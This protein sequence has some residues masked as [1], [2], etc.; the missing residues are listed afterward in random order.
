MTQTDYTFSVNNPNEHRKQGSA[1]LIASIP[2]YQWSNDSSSVSFG[3][4]WNYLQSEQ[5]IRRLS[6]TIQDYATNPNLRPQEYLSDNHLGLKSAPFTGSGY[7]RGV[8]IYDQSEGLDQRAGHTTNLSF[9]GMV[10]LTLTSDIQLATGVRYEY[11][12]LRDSSV[13]ER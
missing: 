5:H 8:L 3:T 7:D 11:S 9:F 4:D 10:E 13:E 2:F 6:Y 12:E 1:G